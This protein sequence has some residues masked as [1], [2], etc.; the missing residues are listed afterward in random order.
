MAFGD[1]LCPRQDMGPQSSA[2]FFEDFWG[3][4][5]PKENI[6][7]PPLVPPLA[8]QPTD[9]CKARFV[10]T[11]API[12]EPEDGLEANTIFARDCSPAEAGN[13]LLDFFDE[14]LEARITKVAPKKYCF[15]ADVF[16][17][18]SCEVKVRIYLQDSGTVALE[19]EK[20]CGDSIAFNSLF[21]RARQRLCKTDA[22]VDSSS[23]PAVAS[24]QLPAGLAPPPPFCSTA[25][26]CAG[27]CALPEGS[28]DQ[29]PKEIDGLTE[30]PL[31]NIVNNTEDPALLAEAA[32][33]LAHMAQD[34]KMA[35]S[36]CKPETIAALKKLSQSNDFRIT[37]PMA[38]ID[39]SVGTRTGR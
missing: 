4:L 18:C 34:S 36:I 13:H 22:S 37:C 2:Q 32:S 15:K 30:E 10:S 26:D 7:S 39:N 29:N 1:D 9:A 19:F 24:S 28:G 27:G 6:V 14:H 17:G 33:G 21:R 3:E 31:L 11:N 20:R 16:L 12:E 38:I 25:L 8:K 5:P 35:R 23:G